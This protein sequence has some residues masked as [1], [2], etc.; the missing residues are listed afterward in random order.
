MKDK[1]LILLLL[2]PWGT[3]VSKDECRVSAYPSLPLAASPGIS[4]SLTHN[5]LEWWW[6]SGPLLSLPAVQP[7]FCPQP[8]TETVTPK[9][10]I[11]S[12]GHIQRTPLHLPPAVA[13]C[14]TCKFLLDELD[15]WFVLFPHSPLPSLTIFKVDVWLSF[16]IPN[17][18]LLPSNDI[19]SSDLFPW[20][21]L[22]SCLQQFAGHLHLDSLQGL[23]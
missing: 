3:T 17:W 22:N 11:V 18:S 2:A 1:E 14:R 6:L 16:F 20:A 9:G 4:V 19:Y 13:L 23:V 7:S 21:S 15:L 10:I 12:N 8:S 5:C